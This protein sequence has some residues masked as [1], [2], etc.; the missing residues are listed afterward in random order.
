MLVRER[1]TTTQRQAFLLFLIVLTIEFQN[2][3]I[4]IQYWSKWNNF[5]V[6]A[7]IILDLYED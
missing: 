6:S 2:K 7:V 5:T 4:F 3:Q 1:K